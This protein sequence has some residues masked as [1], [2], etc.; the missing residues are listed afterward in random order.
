MLTIAIPVLKAHS[1]SV[2]DNSAKDIFTIRNSK[3][4]ST[5]ISTSSAKVSFLHVTKTTSFIIAGNLSE[6]L[7]KIKGLGLE[8]SV[9]NIS[10]SYD[11]FFSALNQ[12]T[13]E[14]NVGWV[15]NSVSNFNDW[16]ELKKVRP[17]T[18]LSPKTFD[19]YVGGFVNKSFIN[20]WDSEQQ[21]LTQAWSDLEEFVRVG[22]KMS[23]NL[24]FSSWLAVASNSTLDYGKLIDNLKNYQGSVPGVINPASPTIVDLGKA[25]GKYGGTLDNTLNTRVSI[26][27]P[28]FLGNLFYSSGNTQQSADILRRIMIMPHYSPFGAANH[29]W[30]QTVGSSINVLGQPYGKK[31]G[32]IVLAAGLGIDWKTDFTTTNKW[33]T[34]IY[35][36]NGSINLGSLI[37]KATGVPKPTTNRAFL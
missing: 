15:A 23:F 16:D 4:F 33:S 29:R 8:L 7:T 32:T 30:I 26:G 11:K 6:H 35:Y 12:P 27:V 37:P 25:N 5:G 2:T 24:Y 28:L 22:A 34:P 3:G 1:Q 20:Y 10:Q 14:L 31:S 9:K 19:L 18:P 13:V 17:F 36:I 21:Q